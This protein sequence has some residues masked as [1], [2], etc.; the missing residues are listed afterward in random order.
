MTGPGAR[1]TAMGGR[2]VTKPLSGRALVVASAM[3]AILTA[4]AVLVLW[5]PATKGLTGK[6]LVTARFDALRIGL[7][8]GVGSGGVVVLYLAWRRQRSTEDTLAHQER[9]SESAEKDAAE[10]RITD[11]YTK[12]ADQLGS[13]KAPVRF[14][15]L[16]ALERLAQDNRTQRQTV[17]NVL[18]AYLRMPF[19]LPGVRPRPPDDIEVSAGADAPT[20]VDRAWEHQR[21]REL[22]ADHRERMQEWEVRLTA[23][24]LLSAHCRPGQGGVANPVDTYWHGLEIDLTGA[25]LEAFDFVGCHVATLSLR[26]ARVNGDARFN[27]AEFSGSAWFNGAE[28]R[29]HAFFDQAKFG[30]DG[31][32]DRAKFSRVTRFTEA[33]FGGTA[34][35][36][37]VVFGG[38]TWFPEVKFGGGHAAFAYARFCG[39]AKFGDAEFGGLTSFKRA[40]FSEAVRFDGTKFDDDAAFIETEFNGEA[41]FPEVTFGGSAWFDLAR[42][43]GDTKFGDVEFGGRVTADGTTFSLGVPFELAAVHVAASQEASTRN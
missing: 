5:W 38:E 7:S 4:V 42:F 26:D 12:A 22:L 10:R 16:Y 32:F 24:R 28:F 29:G 11:L 41:A 20:E 3:I 19:D 36:F 40:V 23:Q 35:F 9:V 27:G 43:C 17:V 18:C 8:L 6:E 14:A 30:D 25:S 15:G 31:T 2:S 33:K 21:Y 37:N 34:G 39:D 13:D 1:P